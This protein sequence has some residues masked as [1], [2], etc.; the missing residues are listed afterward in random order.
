MADPAAKSG[1]GAYMHTG[2]SC[3]SEPA[4]Q[5]ILEDVRALSFFRV[6]DRAKRASLQVSASSSPGRQAERSGM[7]IFQ[8]PRAL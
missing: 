4:A 3:V 5:E 2:D 6:K 8:P 7:L 1:L